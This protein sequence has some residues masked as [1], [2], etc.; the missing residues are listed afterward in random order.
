MFL[1]VGGAAGGQAPDR[2]PPR[3]FGA[4]DITVGTQGQQSGAN[5]NYGGISF[6][7]NLPGVRGYCSPTSGSFFPLGYTTVECGATDAAGNRASAQFTVW[8]RDQQPPRILVPGQI[9]VDAEPGR[10]GATVTYAQP[11]VQDNLPGSRSN[12]VPESGTFFRLGSTLVACTATDGAGNVSSAS[13]TV[14]VVDRRAPVIA[15]RGN[16]TVT[17]PSGAGSAA[18]SYSTPTATDDGPAPTVTCAPPSG[19]NFKVGSTRVTCTAVDRA[20]NKATSGF[21]VIVNRRPVAT[22][23]GS[24][25][26]PTPGG[27]EPGQGTLPPSLPG[28]PTT[29]LVPVSS[30]TVAATTIPTTVETTPQP[31]TTVIPSPLIGGVATTAVD[32][33]P[34]ERRETDDSGPSATTAALGSLG[35]LGVGMVISLIARRRLDRGDDF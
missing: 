10:D 5:V 29:T 30:T 33:G 23:P 6:T 3:I 13:F 22:Q 12:C 31:T 28:G 20:G 34:S 24:G 14:S 2:E 9:V 16:V 32:D 21:W 18:V 26:R 17:A 4:V 7:D 11:T 35:V 1:A 27:T 8:V 19:G 25:T 15:P